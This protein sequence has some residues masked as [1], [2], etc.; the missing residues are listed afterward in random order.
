MPSLKSLATIKGG[1]EERAWERGRYVTSEISPQSIYQISVQPRSQGLFPDSQA[2]EKTLGTRL[3]S[4]VRP[5]NK[6]RQD[7]RL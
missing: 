6:C 7:K 5:N 2:G 3:I 1:N 4:V